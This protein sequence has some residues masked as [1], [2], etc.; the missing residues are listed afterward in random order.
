MPF[1]TICP[2]PIPHI[3]KSLLLFITL[4]LCKINK[5]PLSTT[6]DLFNSIYLFPIPAACSSNKIICDRGMAMQHSC[7][8]NIEAIKSAICTGVVKKGIHFQYKYI[9][10]DW[11]YLKL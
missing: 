10:K 11:L 7:K 9:K 4:F 1:K 3:L 8:N 6:Q 5:T 2:S